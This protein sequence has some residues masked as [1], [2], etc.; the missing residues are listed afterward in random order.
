MRVA[1]LSDFHLGFGY[2]T[3]L[4]NDT[5]DAAMEAINKAAEK[6][7]LILICGDIFDSRSP[8]TSVFAKALKILSNI[9]LGKSSQVKLISS[10]KEIPRICSLLLKKIPVLA[11][12]G[13]HE[14]RVTEINP[15]E[16]LE[17]SGLLIH[18]HLNTL[19]FEKNGEKIA[20]HAMSNVPERYAKNTLNEWNPQPISDC[21]NILVL[22]Q[23][24][25]PYVYSPL[26]L[27]TLS[28]E[29]L[30]KEFDLIV[31]GH[32]HQSSLDRINGKKFLVVGST[33]I[34]Q[35]ERTE[36]ESEKGFFILDTNENKLEFVPL[37]NVRKFFFEE[38]RISANRAFREQ[39]E[40]KIKN[41]VKQEFE[42]KP[43]VK[44]KIY[45]KETEI[46]EQE[47]REIEKKYSDKA[48]LFFVK[49]LEDVEMSE[50]IEFLRNLRE[51]AMSIEE[52]G[53]NLL[54][55]NLDELNF[56]FH[57]NFDKLFKLL[58]KSSEKTLQILLGEQLTLDRLMK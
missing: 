49:E 15:V 51:Q 9:V 21:Y 27:T 20:I 48:L 3:E 10:N 57:V 55:K 36:A 25:K 45:G 32:I 12:H 24:I 6:A 41:F 43:M 44:I 29:N 39:I 4:E 23:N 14:R 1:L 17:A 7:D 37:E 34:I 58:E 54:H 46:I 19:I 42:K 47:L 28:V 13:N 35:L 33:S 2:G 16:A 30:P 22:H 50:K 26:E 8:R 52:I 5:F 38:V 31:D 18:L 40:E 56:S 53:L 11:I